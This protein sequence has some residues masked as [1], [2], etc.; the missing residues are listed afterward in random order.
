MTAR[1]MLFGTGGGT[2]SGPPSLPSWGIVRHSGNPLLTITG[3]E[4]NE[5]YAPAAVELPNGDIYA[6]CKGAERIYAWRSTDGGETFSLANAGGQVIG[7]VGGSWEHTYTLEPVALYDEDTDLIHLWYKGN[8]GNP[9]NWAWG[10]ATATGSDPVSFTKDPA[11][12]ILTADTVEADIGGGNITDLATGSVVVGPDG[13]FHFYGYALYGGVYHLFQATGTT[14][15]DPGNCEAILSAPGGA[16]TVVETPDVIRIPGVG[17]PLYAMFYAIGGTLSAG[18]TIRVGTSP[19]LET[20]DFSDATNVLSPTGTGWEEDATYSGHFIKENAS[21]WLAPK[22]DDL[23]RWRFF[24]SGYEDGV[25]Q[26]GIAYM[27]PN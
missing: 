20:W 17:S 6:Y 13:T 9:N 7:P 18:R 15:N 8:D 16:T 23:A 24:Y 3:G 27:T 10:H 12:P 2:F 5:M 21:P 22:R 11:N 14:F 26:S 19:D 25:A 1:R 4:P